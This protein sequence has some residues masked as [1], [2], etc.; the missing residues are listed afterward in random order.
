MLV[1]GGGLLLM[2]VLKVG[3]AGIVF[4]TIPALDVNCLE[5]F[6]AQHG[7]FIGRDTD[8]RLHL[9]IVPRPNMCIIQDMFATMIP[10]HPEEVIA[11]EMRGPM[12]GRK[13]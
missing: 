6:H 3:K 4:R 5:A 9:A 7:D 2:S 13:P 10:G 1:D 11:S 8:K 12:Q